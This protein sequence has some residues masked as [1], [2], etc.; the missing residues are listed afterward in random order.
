[1][2]LAENAIVTDTEEVWDYLMAT[3]TERVKFE[4]AMERWINST[5]SM[6]ERECNRHIVARTYNPATQDGNGKAAIFL[7]HYPI[8]S[9]DSLTVSDTGGT[10]TTIDIN[11]LSINRRSG[12][13]KIEQGSTGSFW[14]GHQ[15]VSIVYRAGFEG[16]DLAPFQDAVLE[17]TAIRWF[18]KGEN[19]LVFVGSDSIGTSTS[20]TKFDPRRLTHIIQRVVYMYRNL[21]V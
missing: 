8:L 4:P 15:N 11:D 19:P 18:E 9:I 5:S 21:E 2:S 10:A 17:M 7:D 14:R 12:K 16:S 3:E 6:L 1:M 20:N 13:I